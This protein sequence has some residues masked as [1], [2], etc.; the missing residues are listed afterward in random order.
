M[1]RRYAIESGKLVA[2]DSSSGAVVWSREFAG[3]PVFKLL[4]LQDEGDCLVLLDPGA[5]KQPTFENLLRVKADGSVAWRAPL[6]RSH[7]AYSDVLSTNAGIEARP[8][9]GL[10]VLV[11][12]AKGTVREIGFSK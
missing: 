5:S 1:T 12:A 9:Q 11:D 2:R 8:W 7:D 3:C 4:P 10:R 6:P